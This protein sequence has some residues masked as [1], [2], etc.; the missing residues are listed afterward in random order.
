M[1]PRRWRRC[2]RGSSADPVARPGASVPAVVPKRPAEASSVGSHRLSAA[3]QTESSAHEARRGSDRLLVAP[4]VKLLAWS[5]CPH[6]GWTRG[7]VVRS[8]RCSKRWLISR[9]AWRHAEP[10]FERMS[11][12][13]KLGIAEQPSGLLERDA[14]I[15][16]IAKC[17]AVSQMV[18]YLG[19]GRALLCE[20]P[21]ERAPAHAELLG[22]HRCLYP[23]ARQH[24]DEV[25]FHH[26][27]QSR[28]RT[29]LSKQ[30]VGIRL[31][32]AQQMAVLGNHRQLHDAL[33]KHPAVG[34]LRK[35]DWA[36]QEATGFPHSR[37]PSVCEGHACRRKI[38]VRLLAQHAKDGKRGELGK[39]SARLVACAYNTDGEDCL[40]FKPRS[41][42][43]YCFTH[44]SSI[45][46]QVFDRFQDRR[47]RGGEVEEDACLSQIHFCREGETR[48]ASC[49][50]PRRQARESD[51]GTRRICRPPPVTTDLAK[52]RR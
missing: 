40:I 21:R 31:Q 32:D 20:V 24:G 27:P 35:L 48:G 18:E 33:R 9:S 4:K 46:R 42:E 44:R 43:Q 28:C 39:L 14:L 16:E 38:T 7:N 12:C 10:P 50:S 45:P 37:V 47:R 13:W 6:R 41:L 23:A 8:S 51:T 3:A 34:G 25:V 52:A 17:E 26:T 19:E 1:T 36:A 22:D 30:I 29:P 2:R 11:E 15:L 49:S 5:P